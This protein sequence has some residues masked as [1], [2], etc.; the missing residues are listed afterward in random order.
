MKRTTMNNL[1]EAAAVKHKEEASPR[2]AN[3][4]KFIQ[5]VGAKTAGA[6]LAH[7]LYLKHCID[8]K[9]PTQY[10]VRQRDITVHGPKGAVVFVIGPGDSEVESAYIEK[11]N[12]A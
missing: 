12:A 10:I 5:N 4:V 2:T 3:L 1:L 6:V 11:Q 7:P 9:F 8:S